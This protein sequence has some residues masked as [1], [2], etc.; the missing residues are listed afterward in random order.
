[1]TVVGVGSPWGDD[2]VGWCVVDALA[3]R[4]LTAPVR[5]LKLDRPGPGLLDRIQAHRRILLVDAAATGAPAGTLYSIP[6]DALPAA[7]A[8]ASSHSLGVAE[9][10]A[11]GC[12]LGLLPTELRLYLVSI[13]P[14]RTEPADSELSPAVA[15]AVGPLAAIMRRRL[16]AWG[17]ARNATTR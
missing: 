17:A 3:P 10:L 2:R 7:G 12:S 1:V 5:V 11:L 16:V 9:A 13:D 14:R 6:S 4:L 15:A 8:A